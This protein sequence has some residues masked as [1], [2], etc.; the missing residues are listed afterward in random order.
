MPIDTSEPESP[1]WWLK[2]L[3]ERL[4]NKREHF[5]ILDRYYEGENV[6]PSA[7][8]RACRDAYKRLMSLSRSNF[9]ELIVEAPRER[10]QVT[11]FRTGA[12]G[13]DLGDRAAWDIWQGNSLDAD[14]NLITT[15]SL[16]MGLGMAIVGPPAEGMD[17]PLITPE[18]PREVTVEVDPT[19]RRRVMAGLKMF[20]DD[21]KRRHV[22]YV[23]LPGVA[24]KASKP[25]D[26][27]AD[28]NMP[29]DVS[30][31]EWEKQI[32]YG[33]QV[34]PV[35]PFPNRPKLG[36]KRIRGEFETHLSILDRIN[37]TILQRVEIA[38][39]QAFRQRAV[40]ISPNDMPDTDENGNTIDYDDVFEQAPG[41]LWKLPDTAKLWE[42]GQIDLG[43]VRQAIR[44]DIQDLA[45]VTRTPL[46]YLTPDAA[47]GSAEGASLAREGLIFKVRDRIVEASEAWEQVM[48]L[49][50]LFAGDEE[51]AKRSSMEVIWASPERRSLNEMADAG[52]KALKG[53]KTLR[54][55]R[56][57]VWGMTP[58]EIDEA[59]KED[60]RE[61]LRARGAALTGE[62]LGAGD[63]VGDEETR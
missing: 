53:G 7:A 27:S 14:S 35:V 52:T 61:A 56:R 29:V 20:H 15:Q 22:A 46:F 41:A 63:A 34:V 58:Q 30:G 28:G 39:L 17:V 25:G 2:R 16:S 36:G 4:V 59:E 55:V 49:A 11:G 43:P 10:M 42:S 19:R 40:L 9:A 32:K 1:G 44:D 60:T 62:V 3:S 57:D 54:G 24:Y 31:W 45:A 37:Y 23:Y 12:A 5:D 48:S 33:P 26:L 8:S 21:V 47:N 51:R 6:V 50:F 38:T 13:D 18:D